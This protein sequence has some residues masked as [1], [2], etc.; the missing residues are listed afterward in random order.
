MISFHGMALR[1][2]RTAH[3]LIE[4]DWSSTGLDSPAT[5]SPALKTA[6]QLALNAY[7]PMALF[8]GR[9]RLAIYNDGFLPLLAAQAPELGSGPMLSG[10][11]ARVV[12]SVLEDGVP[13][14]RA[15]EP[16]PLE[17]GHGLEEAYFTL[18]FSPVK[19]EHGQTQ[20]VLAIAEETTSTVLGARRS[21]LMA[22]LSEELAT[23]PVMA[24][25]APSIHRAL[26]GAG[27]DFHRAALFGF[28]ADGEL[29]LQWSEPA[30]FAG[31]VTR[32]E[33][34][35]SR[36]RE[37]IPGAAKYQ[38][39]IRLGERRHALIV[40]DPELFAEAAAYVL[41][42]E[43][44]HLVRLGDSYRRLLHNVLS[45]VGDI[46]LHI[47][48]ERRDY[49]DVT[50]QRDERERMYRLLFEYSRDAII[51]ATPEVGV[52]AANPAACEMLGYSEDE[53]VGVTASEIIVNEGGRLTQALSERRKTGSFLG[54]VKVRRKD[55][56]EA[57]VDISSVM[58][59]DEASGGARAVN[60]L[61]DA[62][63]RLMAE[64]HVASAARLEAIGQLTGGISHDFNNLLS[65]II[66]GAED[67]RARL[68]ESDPARR[69]ADLV[70]DASLKASHLTRQLLAFSRQ[71][72]MELGAVELAGLVTELDQILHRAVGPAITVSLDLAPHLYA[73]TDGA[74][75]QS[76]ILNLCINARDAMPRGGSLTVTAA[77]VRLE[78]GLA[79]T[80]S[81]PAGEY[82]R[83]VVA[84]TGVGID[85]QHLARVV[86]PFFTTK[87]AGKGTGLGLSMVYGL[88]R[89][90]GGGLHLRSERG[91]GTQAE[92]Y[93]PLAQPPE[94]AAV[95][96]PQAEEPPA[97]VPAEPPRTA[98]ARHLLVVEDNELLS[99]MLGRILQGA[100]YRVTVC[101]AA[102]PALDLIAGGEEI[103]LVITDI[104]LGAGM[105]GWT[106]AERLESRTPG[107]PVVTMSGF[108]PADPDAD[109]GAWRAPMLR[110]PFRPREI[111]ALI[112]QLLP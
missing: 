77:Q 82:A 10:G 32:D 68:P 100:G 20:G 98:A 96:E 49:L 44:H 14:C 6:A 104:Q 103:A 24:P 19:D 112:D 31:E 56:S 71:Q 39:M 105:D 59:H 53:I 67:L 91:R 47:L 4:V 97:P 3:R 41:V 111:L 61:R 11:L 64:R 8:W 106:L 89:Q 101:E 17:R 95:P 55:G 40:A 23:H 90:S 109:P 1:E 36:L 81:L 42:V 35:S 29:K 107:L 2:S 52:I 85:E 88:A 62:G 58:F 13:S 45:A 65:V 16:I 83:I 84:D 60:L 99:S 78:A 72:P 66:S 79:E 57:A 46:C 7:H 28:R 21:Q 30:D 74:L 94:A 69:S 108:A 48:E 37:E 87:P 22:R 86:E 110:K 63:P 27:R 80:L 93:L 75:L 9:D 70:L 92:I 18:S 26:C 102:E 43:A 25:T 5:W 38:G 12:D 34:L 73:R 54:E 15:D 50:R 51:I 76:A 33:T